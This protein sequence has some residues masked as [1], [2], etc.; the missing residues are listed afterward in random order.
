MMALKRTSSEFVKS[1]TKNPF[2][3]TNSVKEIET[4]REEDREMKNQGTVVKDRS[5]TA[6]SNLL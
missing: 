3:C 5:T 6:A 2:S 1:I 4:H